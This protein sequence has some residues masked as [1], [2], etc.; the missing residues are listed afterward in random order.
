M[1]SCAKYHPEHDRDSC[2]DASPN[3][4]DA[5]G[6]NGCARCTAIIMDQRDELLEVLKALMSHE[7]ICLDDLI[8][9][10][11]E[12]ENQGWEGSGVKAWSDAISNAKAAIA[13]ATGRQ[14][15]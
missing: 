1:S 13:K 4:A 14:D 7:H 6:S 11:R 2:S 9:Q 5:R 8:Y 10:V 12:R 15:V 3:N